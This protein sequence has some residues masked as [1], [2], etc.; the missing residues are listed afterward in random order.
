VAGYRVFLNSTRVA[1]TTARAY[2]ASRL[3]CGRTYVVRVDAYD[4]TG[5]SWHV[6]TLTAA[7]TPCR[8]ATAPAAPAS[9]RQVSTGRT[10]LVLEWSAA[11]DNA[12]VAGYTVYREGVPLLTTQR[13]SAAVTGLVCGAAYTLTVDAFDASGNRSPRKSIIASTASCGD[14]TPPTAPRSVRVTATSAS[15]ISIAWQASEDDSAVAGYRT[16]VDG[17]PADATV[18]TSKTFTGLRC[19]SSYT[20]SVSGFDA[21]GNESG[22]A[23]IAAG[24]SPCP[25]GGAGDTT[26]PTSPESLSQAGGSSSS[27]LLVWAPASDDRGVA[28]YGVYRDGAKVGEPSATSYAVTGLACGSW[29][30]LAVDA[31]DGSGNRSSRRTLTAS[32]ASC[33]DATPPPVPTGLRQTS[34]TETSVS[35]AWNATGGDTAG[36]RLFKNGSLVGS[37]A[38]TSFTFTAL[39]CGTTFTFGVEAYDAAG[40]HSPRSTTM[41]A[42]AACSDA[43]PP[44]TPGS[45]QTTGSTATSVSLAWS[46]ATDNVGV[47]GYSLYVA[48]SLVGSTQQAS[49]TFGGLT[50]GTSYVFGVEAYDAAGN[51]SSRTSATASTAACA[52]PAPPAPAPPPGAVLYVS[53]TGSDANAC[54]QAAPCRSFGRAYKAAAPGT[55]VLVAAG[56]YPSQEI[57]RDPAKTSGAPVVFQPA[58][59]EVNVNGTLDFGQDQF[60]RLGPVNV[61]IRNMKVQYLR[62]WAGS[63]GLVWEN[64]DGMHFD[65]FDSKDVQVLGGDFGPCQAP[66]DDPACVN[67]IAGTSSNVIVDGANIHD[68]TSTDLVAYHVDGMFIR[69]GS[70]IVVR[71]S[72]FWGNM[73]TNIR[74]QKQDC[75]DN[76]NV[77]FENNWF[78]APLQ[79]DGVSPR[80]DAINV[81]TPVVGGITVQF[82]SFAENAGPQVVAP[83]LVKANLMQNSS[84]APGVVYAYN[85]FVPFSPFTGQAPCGAT[86]RKV[87]TFGYMLSSLT[88][89][90]DF[91]LGPTSAAVDAVPTAAGCPLTDAKGTPRPRGGACDAGAD[92]R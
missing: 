13:T 40:N 8:D 21:A 64:V 91:Q 71:N 35:L 66:R 18:A 5:R 15:S 67:R 41:L 23:L 44:S 50:C 90:F 52:T 10:E 92:E 63:S 14:T 24:T 6:G 56:T 49:Y 83:A 54:T 79:G 76:V 9:L 45:L 89:G 73:I 25:S 31:V 16:S 81:D 82:N 86:D 58:G 11:S 68:I 70:N 20:L 3:A 72:R 74:V 57:S 39:T 69:G 48:G 12:G 53:T 22:A 4:S 38:S 33:D 30:E 19:G 43:T 55:T 42:T 32:T 34:R 28:A 47:T 65:V 87:L 27:I 61:T 51:R 29:Y 77:L 59:S 78:N 26:P 36:Y 7:T 84:C 37:T 85:L 62:S 17:L 46:P 60:D 2:A 75:C 88:G 1:S 80:S